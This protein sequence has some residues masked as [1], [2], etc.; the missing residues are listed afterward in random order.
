MFPEKDGSQRPAEGQSQCPEDACQ[1]HQERVAQD[2]EPLGRETCRFIRAL[3]KKIIAPLQRQPCHAVD[4]PPSKVVPP[5]CSR[6]N[7]WSPRTKYRSH[8]CSPP[9]ADGPPAAD[10]GLFA[11][12]FATAHASTAHAYGEQP[13][14]CL[15]DQNKVR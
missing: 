13:G 11:I 7:N 5:D 14:H 3:I 10:C 4:S 12:A 2:V 6:Q 8:T 1:S 15:F 9:A